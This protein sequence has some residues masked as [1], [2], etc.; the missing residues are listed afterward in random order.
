M[1]GGSVKHRL[2]LF[3]F[4]LPVVA[5]SRLQY[6]Q[7]SKLTK[8]IRETALTTAFTVGAASLVRCLNTSF[9]R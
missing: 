2:V 6:D 1:L 9:Q 4:A 7:P 8:L 5:G 3:T